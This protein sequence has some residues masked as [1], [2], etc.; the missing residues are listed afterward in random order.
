MRQDDQQVPDAIKKSLR[1]MF[2]GQLR[3]TSALD[4]YEFELF[5]WYMRETEDLLNDMLSAERTYIREQID[6]GPDDIN[7]SGMVAVE[8]YLK[9]VRYSHVIYMAS[10]L[11][12]FLER[13]CGRLTTA[14]GAQN[15]PFTTVE[16]KGDQWSV[17]RKFLERYGKFNVPEDIWSEIRVL[18]LLRNN[19]VHDNGSTS[20]LKPNEKTM[21]AKRAGV[22]LSGYEVVLEAEYVRSAFVAI[23]SLVQFVESRLGELIDRAVRPR[24]VA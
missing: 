4:V 5:E 10:L 2:L 13:S 20:K 6:N 7:D 22:K 14:V 23:R 3:D 15:L 18:I 9:R 11:E 12:T 8:Y 17:K 1:T 16:L 19:L 21:L 24:T